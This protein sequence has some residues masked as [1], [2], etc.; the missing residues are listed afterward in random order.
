MNRKELISRKQRRS[1]NRRLAEHYKYVGEEQLKTSINLIS[2][3]KLAVKKQ[4]VSPRQVSFQ[5]L[6]HTPDTHWLEI[7]GLAD[8]DIITQ[9]VKDFGLH[10][11]DAKDILTP[12]HIAKVELYGERT[13][14]ILN[15]CYYDGS[16]ELHTEHICLLVAGNTIVTFKE[17]DSYSIFDGVK[18][19]IDENLLDIRANGTGQLLIHLLN[20]IT[21]SLVEAATQTEEMLEDIE[22]LLLDIHNIPANTGQLILGRRKESI[23]IR[24][25]AQPLKEQFI[26]LSKNPALISSE[27]LPLFNDVYD[28]ILFTLQTTESCREIISSLVDLYISNNDLRMNAIMKRL[29]VV[30][31]I[32]IPLTF[33]AGIWG[34]NFQFMPELSWEYGYLFAWIVMLL[35]G[36]IS[37]LYLRRKD[38]N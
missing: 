30:S 22:E 28:Q 31:T 33:L 34:M 24:K 26:K 2:Y 11:I 32:F 36:L 4:P 8:A 16:T 13:L 6:C 3:N 35:A 27:L 21:S 17:G 7:N 25:N 14:I 38:W 29:T 23:T 5:K 12:Q 15:A 19:A 9:I 20:A 1:A 37:W 18:K 10:N